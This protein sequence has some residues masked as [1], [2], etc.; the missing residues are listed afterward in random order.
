MFKQTTIG[1]TNEHGFFRLM[2]GPS[3]THQHGF[4]S[5]K[6]AVVETIASVLVRTPTG[7][8]VW[9]IVQTSRHEFV[10]PVTDQSTQLS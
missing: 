6:S 8:V 2:A 5:A 7:S 4:R 3:V 9:T 1:Q 10:G